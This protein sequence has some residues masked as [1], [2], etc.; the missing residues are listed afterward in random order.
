MSN[1]TK[2]KTIHD[3]LAKLRGRLGENSFEIEDRWEADLCAI[4]I[5]N[6]DNRRSLAYISTYDL[7]EDQYY[8]E[9]ESLVEPDEAMSFVMKARYKSVGFEK[10]LTVVA[11]H[12]GLKEKPDG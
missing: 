1:L 7:P 3:L 9:L 4:G 8:L 6:P 10:L 5:V 12:L 11:E 2:D